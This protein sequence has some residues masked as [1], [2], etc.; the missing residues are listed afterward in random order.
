MFEN[1]HDVVLLRVKE[2]MLMAFA[3]SLQGKAFF[4][5]MCLKE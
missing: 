4:K 1:K 5:R 3:E 2:N